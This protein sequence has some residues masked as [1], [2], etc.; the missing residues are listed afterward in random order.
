MP[1]N[2]PQVASRPVGSPTIKFPSGAEILKTS[3]RLYK[4]FWKN[5]F[6]LYSYVVVP[7]LA[8]V[9]SFVM[10]NFIFSWLANQAILNETVITILVIV[11][12]LIGI[13]ALI[14]IILVYIAVYFG[15]LY[16]IKGIFSNDL[17]AYNAFQNGRKNMAELFWI[18]FL[19]GL[20]ILLYSLL[21]VIPGIVWSIW[22]AFGVFIF[23][24]EG[25]KGKKA[26]DRSKELVKGFWWTVAA[27]FLIWTIF[28]G[29]IGFIFQL[30]FA[31]PLVTGLNESMHEAMFVISAIISVC[32]SVVLYSLTLLYN[33]HVYKN[34]MGIKKTNPQAKDNMP[35]LKKVGIVVLTIVFFGLSF[36]LSALV[37]KNQSFTKANPVEDARIQVRDAKRMADI[38]QIQVG[39]ELYYNDNGAYPKDL[40]S[41]SA[42]QIPEDAFV[43]PQTSVPHYYQP[44]TDAKNY[45]ICANF[46]DNDEAQAFVQGDNCW[47]SNGK[48]KED[49]TN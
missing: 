2:K 21:L 47:D 24:F 35:L 39:L 26:L 42:F 8:L 28:S 16:L 38:K 12:A 40:Q 5:F 25:I 36:S 23:A 17:S 34:L 7:A 33:Y 48:L 19:G 1:E 49:P 6:N 13:V 9:L 30:L 15:Q 37:P 10:L 41:L 46:E 31:I 32:L 3:L 4:K 43:D 45:I 29:I 18:N 14:G 11:L 44:A 20:I 27:R 22:L